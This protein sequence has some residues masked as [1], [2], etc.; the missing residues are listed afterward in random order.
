MQGLSHAV[1]APGIVHELRSFF[2]PHPM[3][4]FGR[5]QGDLSTQRAHRVGDLCDG[6]GLLRRAREARPD[7]VGE[8]FEPRPGPIAV[9]GGIADLRQ[10]R[11]RRGVNRAR[12]GGAGAR[13]D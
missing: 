9:H 6:G 5:L 10:G 1:R 2:A 12:C 4:Y 13:A 8:I 3:R 11:E 7:L